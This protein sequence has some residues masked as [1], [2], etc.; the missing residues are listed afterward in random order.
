[1]RSLSEFIATTLDLDIDSE[2][3]AHIFTATV[4]HVLG[5]HGCPEYHR[6]IKDY[7]DFSKLE[8][9]PKDFRL[10]VKDFGY[11]FFN[12]K[13]Y[14]LGIF[15]S[16]KSYTE[17]RFKTRAPYYGIKDEDIMLCFKSFDSES[18]R[19]LVKQVPRYNTI[20]RRQVY[21]KAFNSAKRALSILVRE[22]TPHCNSLSRNKLLFITKYSGMEMYEYS[23][24]L[25]LKA[26]S[27]YY[28]MLPVDLEH[29]RKENQSEHELKYELNYMRRAATNHCNNIIKS[30]TTEG[31][32][33]LVNMGSDNADNAVYV[34][35]TINESQISVTP[36]DTQGIEDYSAF[37]SL[38]QSGALTGVED[39]HL[40]VDRILANMKPTKR[41][42]VYKL[43][44]KQSGRF[45][46][47][48]EENNLIR[49]NV[50][51]AHDYFIEKPKLTVA[52]TIGRYVELS[53]DCVLKCMD[54]LTSLLNEGDTV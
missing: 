2:N 7:A 18:K 14:L 15:K 1:M 24:E 25:T 33:R 22:V 38:E 8:I 30:N 44:T 21:P 47:W 52:K 43:L 11:A 13:Y 34:V 31:K 9:S 19:N 6:A 46:R 39:F 3:V 27:A 26:I 49:S 20:L 16:K 23:S 10:K 28:Q 29:K 4:N 42:L 5:V 36:D 45:E 53:A 12:I 17:R 50:K 40:T 35:R 37:A 51:T 41:K 48:L 54:E 32:S